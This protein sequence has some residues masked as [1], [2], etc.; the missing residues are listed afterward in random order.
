MCPVTCETTCSFPVF[1]LHPHSA[2]TGRESST[3]VGILYLSRQSRQRMPEV[4]QDDGNQYLPPPRLSGPRPV[5]LVRS[6]DGCVTI[7]GFR[8]WPVP[9]DPQDHPPAPSPSQ[10]T[11]VQ[12]ICWQRLPKHSLQEHETQQTQGNRA[13]MTQCSSLPYYQS[14]MSMVSACLAYGAFASSQCRECRH[15]LLHRSHPSFYLRQELLR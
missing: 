2:A 11:E 9:Q 6:A 13:T 3:R 7:Q 10:R 8:N 4:P 12:E 15:C 14:S 5:P 1:N